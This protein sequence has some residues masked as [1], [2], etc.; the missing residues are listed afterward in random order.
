MA[1][2]PVQRAILVDLLVFGDDKAAN[3]GQRTGFHRNTV[4]KHLGIL[5][6]EGELRNKGGGVFTLLDSG[7]EAA[8]SLIRAGEI[9][10]GEDSD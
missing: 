5:E 9:P 6:R 7:R 4:S 10:Y 1:R 8:Q 3:I 2:T